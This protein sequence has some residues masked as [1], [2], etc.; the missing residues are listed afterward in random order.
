MIKTTTYILF[1]LV[2]NLANAQT[3]FNWETA[4][5]DGDY[6]SETIDEITCT[7]LE[8]NHDATAADANGFGNSS[9]Y[10]VLSSRVS[11]EIKF[12]FSEAVN[13]VSILA[14]EGNVRNIDYTFIPIGGSNNPVKASLVNGTALVNLNWTNITSF[15]V[16]SNGA[17][18]GFDDLIV[19][20]PVVYNG[21]D[22]LSKNVKIYPNPIQDFLYIKNINSLKIV[23]IYNS[24]GQ[25]ILATNGIKNKKIDFRGLDKGIYY[26]QLK[27]DKTLITKKIIYK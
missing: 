13:V 18:Y 11:S 2:L 24:V 21:N 23:K 15:I 3:A 1:F 7:F 5:D 8:Y 22:D 17:W 4:K 14:L 27:T 26:A 19:Q 10:I 20:K 6:I 25:V 16:K 9:G 12:N